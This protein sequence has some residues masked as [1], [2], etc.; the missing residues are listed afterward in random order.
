MLGD[1]DGPA[2]TAGTVRQTVLRPN[3][4]Y[5]PAGASSNADCAPHNRYLRAGTALFRAADI[6]KN[7]HF[8]PD[9]SPPQ[10]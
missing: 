8:L 9:E 5:V 10:L 6:L 3:F 2:A 4:E 7:P 1:K